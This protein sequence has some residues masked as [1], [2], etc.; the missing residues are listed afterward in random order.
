MIPLVFAEVRVTADGPSPVL[1]L[2]EAQGRRRLAIWITAAGGNAVLSALDHEEPGRI[3]PH[4]LMLEALS[5]VDAVVE[6]VRILS[7]D[8]GV[9]IA[10]I[11][12][13]GHAVPCRVSDG[14]AL[15]LRC[16]APLLTTEE[17]LA[18]VGVLR[19]AAAP[20]AD[21]EDEVEQFRE[22][23]DQINPGDFGAEP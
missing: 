13:N 17:L 12:V 10:E 21:P 6:Q 4:D 14:V 18:E 1:I 19:D 2:D 15:A 16:G 5:V 7:F 22:F 8:D 11:V 23:L 3:S 9:F 20:G